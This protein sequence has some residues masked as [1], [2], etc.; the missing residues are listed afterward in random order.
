LHYLGA[1]TSGV[2]ATIRVLEWLKQRK[3][4]LIRFDPYNIL[5][6]YGQETSIGGRFGDQYIRMIAT[7][8][9]STQNTID[10]AYFEGFN[11]IL[12]WKHS[13]EKIPLTFQD[14]TQNIRPQKLTYSESGGC[15][16]PL[17]MPS[18][19]FEK[20]KGS[21]IFKFENLLN[22]KKWVR[23]AVVDSLG[24]K[25]HST[26]SEIKNLIITFYNIEEEFTILAYRQKYYPKRYLNK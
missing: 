13:L 26:K 5:N 12:C 22:R 6:G 2:L 20:S 1:V 25:Y 17:S 9:A 16:F 18:D 24:I 8:K 4:L 11:M 15:S 21:N 14:G 10:D 23:A 7:H 19:Q 3:N